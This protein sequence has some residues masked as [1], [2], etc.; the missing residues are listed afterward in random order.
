MLRLAC[1]LSL[2]IGTVACGN[3]TGGDSPAAKT[4][5]TPTVIEL[6]ISGPNTLLIGQTAGYSATAVYSDGTSSPASPVWTSAVPAVVEIS[7]GGQVTAWTA[8]STT[9]SANLAGRNAA[10]GVQV[11]NPLVGQWVLAAAT[12]PGN[13]SGVNT[14]TKTFTET[15]WVINQPNPATGTVV[16]RHGGHYTLRG[17]EYSETVDYANTSTASLIGRTFT[18]T[19]KAEG[20]RF[21]QSSSNANE[22]WNRV[23]Q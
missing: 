23:S 6:R 17:T 2:L 9:I 10:S 14:R 18:A 11:T 5:P 13:P 20:S 8:G 19:V 7:S 1:V 15:E 22:E 12:N 21:T 4:A 3:T 16:F